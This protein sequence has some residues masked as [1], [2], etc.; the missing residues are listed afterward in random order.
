MKKISILLFVFVILVGC[1]GSKEKFEFF[2]N[3][4]FPTIKDKQIVDV[5]LKYYQN[6]KVKRGDLVVFNLTDEKRHIRRVI[7]LPN[8]TVH[9]KE[10]KIYLNEKVVDSKFVF[11]DIDAMGNEDLKQGIKLGDNQYFVIGDNAP[12]SKDSRII[13]PVN[14]DSI[15]GKVVNIKQ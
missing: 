1:A 11:T 9:I 6:N 7:G 10:G 14:R 5:D 15:K 13:G 3:S 4:M 8:E 2:G 12:I